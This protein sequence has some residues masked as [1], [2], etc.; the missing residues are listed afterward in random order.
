MIRTP[1]AARD[2]R[3]DGLGAKL[4][5]VDWALLFTTIA[6]VA[7]GLVA[8]LSASRGPDLD[9]S[10]FSRQALFAVLGLVALSGLA[11]VDYREARNFVGLIYLISVASLVLVLTP[12]GTEVRATR[13]W[14][15]IAGFSL[16]P[17]EFVKLGLIVFLAAV[18]SG[19]GSLTMAGRTVVGLVGTGVITLLVLAQGEVGS[20]L[21][22]T[23]IALGI[24]LVA[25]VPRR[26]LALL[27][28]LGIV[29]STLVV[30]TGMLKEYQQQRLTSFLDLD[31][32]ARGAGYNQ[33]QS[34]T[35]VGSGGLVGKG[36]FEGPQTQLSFVPEQ[37]TDFIFTVI[38]EELGFV[39]GV[40]LLG[41][42]SV[43]MIRMF[44]GA[45]LARDDFGSLICIGV[46]V[47][48]LFQL[49]QNVGMNVGIMPI[50]GIP[51]PFISY[52]GSSL[53]TTMA[54]IGLV[55]SVSVHR[56]RGTPV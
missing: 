12:L 10:L 30:S 52:G 33:R 35:A 28:V 4:L 20:V 3:R 50:T 42:Y 56:H 7:F 5:N 41:L 37:E 22:Y 15:Q 53:L 16:Q 29:G 39:G 40:A 9:L 26:Y 14:F 51:L 2:R 25:G 13:G 49:F 27:V 36:L 1:P 23:A 48:L 45:Q 38:G 31:A 55:L 46:L 44:R 8:I 21:V 43:L 54:A 18:F 6:L 19:R 11:M 17:A 47:M 24:M 32:D 34:I